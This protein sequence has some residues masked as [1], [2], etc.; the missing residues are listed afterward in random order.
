MSNRN[1]SVFFAFFII[2]ATTL[3]FGFAIGDIDN[4]NHHHIFEL[5]FAI[6]INLIALTMKFGTRSQMDSTQLA[7]SVVSCLQL[8]GACLIWLFATSETLATVMTSI[9]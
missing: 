4:P 8:T 6:V 1:N 2:L 5:F 3:N 9:V 7:T